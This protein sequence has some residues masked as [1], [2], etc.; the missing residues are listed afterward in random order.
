[1]KLIHFQGLNCYHDC[2]ITLANHA[3]IQY[4]QSFS[5]LWSEWEL[6]FDPICHSFLT[7]RMPY[8]LE[9]M[10]MKLFSPCVSRE[11]RE[12]SWSGLPAGTFTLIGMDTFLIPWTPLYQLQHGPHYFIAQKGM[13]DPQVC[14]DPTYG[15]CGQTCSTLQRCSDAYAL[16]PVEIT[17][18]TSLPL[19]ASATLTDQAHEVLVGHPKMLHSFLEMAEHWIQG[20]EETAFFPAK[21]TDALLSGRYL[22]RHFL[23]EEYGHLDKA[24]FFQSRGYFSEWQAVK[25]GFY[26]A[27]LLHRRQ[28]VFEEACHRFSALLD[29]EIS[30][31]EEVLLEQQVLQRKSKPT[32][33]PWQ[34]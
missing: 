7:K 26:K 10:G 20:G 31:A 2:M 29:Q 22:Y 34:N 15:V 4:I 1:M 18:P 6:C 8:A 33:P 3:G 25:N 14:F 5:R 27:A 19:S 32:A 11:A 21:F 24:P 28:T 17:S 30:F 9:A 12:V 16:I 23:T 13:T